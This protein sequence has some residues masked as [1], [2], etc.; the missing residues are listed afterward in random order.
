MRIKDLTTPEDIQKIQ[1]LECGAHANGGDIITEDIR[2]LK[3]T[4]A[5][6]MCGAEEKFLRITKSRAKHGGKRP[7]A[8]RPKSEHEKINIT[9]RGTE[10]EKELILEA[11]KDPRTRT[12]LLLKAIELYEVGIISPALSGK[13]LER[14]EEKKE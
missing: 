8:G 14:L 1:C 13:T 5:C 9:M 2:L 7:N 4:G 12:K 3:E 6:I 10:E 11:V